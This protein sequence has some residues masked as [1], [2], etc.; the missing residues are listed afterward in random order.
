MTEQHP[1]PTP[2]P[3]RTHRPTPGPA[4]PPSGLTRRETA[5]W[6]LEQTVAEAQRRAGA[7]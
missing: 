6:W 3:V 7:R 2:A 5:D 4:S 1:T